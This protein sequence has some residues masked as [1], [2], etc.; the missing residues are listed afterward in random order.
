MLG[1]L[2]AAAVLW[3]F[4]KGVWARAESDVAGGA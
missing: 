2:G 4:R 1:I 3:I